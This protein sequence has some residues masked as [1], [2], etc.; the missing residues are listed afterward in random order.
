MSM[1]DL[2]CLSYDL[3]AGVTAFS[4]ERNADDATLGG[5]GRYTGF[6]VCFYTGDDAAH[7]AL[8]AGRLAALDGMRD[9]ILVMPR[10]VH[11]TDVAVITADNRLQDNNRYDALV[12]AERGVALGINTADCVPVVLADADAHVIGA[13]HAGWRGA[14]G[15]VIAST[16]AAMTALGA[17]TSRIHAALGPSICPDCF[18]VGEEVAV[19][20]G[21]R[22]TLRSATRPHDIS[23]RP[24]VDLRAYVAQQLVDA[25]IPAAHISG[26]PP[27]SRCTPGRWCS[28]RRDGIDSARTLTVIALQ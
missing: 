16:V 6:N 27:C 21:P 1:S 2:A 15:G 9:C 14:V 20:F 8:C 3:G 24:H 26:K 7:T 10:Q 18:E 5:S 25:G 28:A 13:A 11:G 23:P 12:T 4:V 17:D 22:F 19:R